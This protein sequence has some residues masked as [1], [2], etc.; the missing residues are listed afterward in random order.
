MTAQSIDGKAIAA[1]LR[2]EVAVSAN[3]LRG[4]GIAPTL[5]VVLVGDDP[6]ALDRLEAIIRAKRREQGPT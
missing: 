6:A 2:G 3:E 1:R 5:A 4:R